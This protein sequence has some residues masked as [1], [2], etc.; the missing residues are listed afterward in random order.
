MRNI[1]P[2]TDKYMEPTVAGLKKGESKPIYP[3][4]R[5]DL[6]HLPEAKKWDLGKAYKIEMEVKLVGL[7][8]SRFDNSA[9]FEIHKIGSEDVG[10]SKAEEDKEG[11]DDEEDGE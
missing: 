10:E 4:F 6:N 11:E 5:V 3:T 2:K 9:E 1:K 7:S 8:Q